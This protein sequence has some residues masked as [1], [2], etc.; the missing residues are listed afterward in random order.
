M[1][2]GVLRFNFETDQ[3]TLQWVTDYCRRKTTSNMVLGYV[4]IHDYKR[5]AKR[6]PNSSFLSLSLHVA[7]D[8]FLLPSPFADLFPLQPAKIE[9]KKH[10]Q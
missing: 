8:W 10:R 6:M 5:G 2:E 4:S 7:D 3:K 1:I 9:K